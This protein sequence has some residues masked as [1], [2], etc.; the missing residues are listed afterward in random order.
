MLTLH[1]KNTQ[2]SMAVWVNNAVAANFDALQDIEIVTPHSDNDKW[3]R[4]RPAVGVRINGTW[5]FNIHA[6]SIRNDVIPN[7]HAKALTQAVVDAVGNEPWR[8]LGDFNSEARSFREQV[9]AN[10]YYATRNGKPQGVPVGTQQSGYSLDFMTASEQLTNLAVSISSRGGS[11]YQPVRF[12][13]AGTRECMPDWD[14]RT[15]YDPDALAARAVQSEDACVGVD[16]VV[17]MGDS[18]I[19]GEGGRWQGNGAG[20]LSYRSRQGSAFGTD[21]AAFNCTGSGKDEV[22][23]QDPKRVYGETA[24]GKEMC[25]RSDLAPIKSVGD[26]LGIPAE[27]RFNVACSGAT[28]TD[29]TDNTFKGEEPQVKQLAKIAAENN[30]KYVVPSIGGNDIGFSDI[31]F[32]CVVGYVGNKPCSTNGRSVRMAALRGRP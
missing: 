1:Q 8:V 28:T 26:V 13:P 10:T 16:A 31:G 4:S 3:I 6:A 19:S 18:Y 29:V 25:H 32:N 23:E 21:R 15:L 5:Y 9:R 30:V 2:K 12:A 22:C 11:D 24:S 27:R 17:S 7:P 20:E 14:G